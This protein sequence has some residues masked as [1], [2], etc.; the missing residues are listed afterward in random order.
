MEIKDN[1][2]QAFDSVHADD[3]AKNAA[4]KFV[5]DK[6]NGYKAKKAFAPVRLAAAVAAVVIVFA[7]VGALASYL[8]PVSVISV[9]INPSVELNL[10]IFD[11]VIDAVA[12]ND[13]AEE[14][15][16][17]VNIK[18]LDYEDAVDALLDNDIIASNID[19]GGVAQI[20]A[21]SRISSKQ[22]QLYNSLCS[23][24][25]SSGCCVY[26]LDDGSY[27]KEAHNA[28]VSV[29][30]YR[31]YLELK[32]VYSDATVDD[33]KDLTMKQIRDLIE[34]YGGDTD[35]VSMQSAG[36]G[37]SHSAE[38]GGGSGREYGHDRGSGSRHRY[39]K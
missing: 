23:H 6:T 35:N 29:G 11:R 39:N 18:N 38:H 5:Y 20:T 32:K 12:Y 34:S 30:K 21:A 15:L 31:A 25:G 26:S 37:N 19:S 4:K 2:K 8:V 24:A 3:C 22:D 14:I 7:A 1:I 33:I 10:N 9:D 17:S 36:G 16:A 27:I 13:D 28:G